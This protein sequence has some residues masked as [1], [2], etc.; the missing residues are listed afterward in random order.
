[1]RALMSRV[2][3]WVSLSVALLS[4][5]HLTVSIA[6]SRTAVQTTTPTVERKPSRL[7]FM[8][9]RAI[10]LAVSGTALIVLSPLM[11]A[12]AVLIR[13][14]SPGGAVFAQQRVGV[15]VKVR[16]GQKLWEIKPFIVYKFRTM[17]QDSRSD[18]H[19]A[20]VK[21]LIERDEHAMHSMNGSANGNGK[22]KLNDDPRITRIGK[23]LR[24]T[25]LDELPQFWN[26]FKGDM[27]LVGP[28]PALPYEVDMYTPYH[29]R[30]LEAQPGLTGLWQVSAR[31]SV[32]FDSM[33]DLDVSYIQA[34]SLWNDLR[35]IWQTPFAV[36]GGKGAA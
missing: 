11:L 14:D 30:R 27:T 16:R 6:A 29:L 19:M 28:R 21:A 36:L 22:Y 12:I 9:K 3:K 32:D 7:Y 17:H 8:I 25:S 5:A 15:R 2:S 1:M 18:L 31:S 23:F 24:K 35:I 34:Q 13:L 33:V 10:D 20:F 4:I 26:V